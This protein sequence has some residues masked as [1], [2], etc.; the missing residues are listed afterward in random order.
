MMPTFLLHTTTVLQI[1]IIIVIIFLYWFLQRYT[2]S[3][4]QI[5]VVTR[6]CTPASNVIRSSVCNMI[7][8]T[9][10]APRIQVWLLGCWDVCAPLDLDIR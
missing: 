6:F 2:N 10:L 8:I 7:H 5:A 3:G 9:V 1:D 4:C